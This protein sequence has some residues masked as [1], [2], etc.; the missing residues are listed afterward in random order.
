MRI[1]HIGNLA[2]FP[3][4]QVKAL[5]RKGVDADLLIPRI[6]N[7][8]E[9]PRFEDP[10]SFKFGFPSWIRFWDNRHPLRKLRLMR[11]LRQYDF[12]HAYTEFPIAA[13]FSSKPYIAQSTGSDLRELAVQNTWKGF[14]LRLA[15]RR[16]KMLL[17]G[18]PDQLTVIKKL[19]LKKTFFSPSPID[20]DKYSPRKEALRDKFSCE[21]LIFHPS[22]LEWR[23]KGNDLFLR[24]YA[25]LVEEVKDVFLLLSD[26]GV[27]RERTKNLLSQLGISQHVEFLPL[28][29]QRELIKYYNASD[30][31]IDQFLIGSIGSIALEA[32]SCS[33]PVFACISE[34]RFRLYY[35]ELPPIVNTR[36]ENQIFTKLYELATDDVERRKIG[37]K[38][39]N[40]VLNYHDSGKVA[41]KLVQIYKAVMR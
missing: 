33:K 17:F 40:W 25:R 20:T 11:I 15:Y 4:R 27:D 14:L 32:M 34:E 19:R 5:R 41:E 6:H 1:I 30:I 7:L 28:L 38:S 9:D 18:N 35:P 24:A 13:M 10:E 29:A 12:L 3:Y 21:V 16:S 2:N 26:R 37:E 36:T 31:V 22:A 23:L 39:R 8:T